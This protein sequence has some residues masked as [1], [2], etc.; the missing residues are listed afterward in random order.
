MAIPTIVC[1]GGHCTGGRGGHVTNTKTYDEYQAIACY[2]ISSEW[3]STRLW[4]FFLFFT[5]L[6]DWFVFSHLS[7][8]YF[9]AITKS[10]MDKKD[11][12]EQIY[13]QDFT[14]FLWVENALYN[15][16]EFVL[17]DQKFTWFEPLLSKSVFTLI[18]GR[19][20]KLP[21]WSH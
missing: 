4:I 11:S 8:W 21:I 9:S 20:S 10:L 1:T 2:L 15:M 12:F 16:V 7:V 13:L 6:P 18:F 3:L 14:T 17:E 19:K 5:V